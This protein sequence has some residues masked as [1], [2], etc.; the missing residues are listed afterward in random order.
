[1]SNARRPSG[2]RAAAKAEK[3]G[4]KRLTVDFRGHEYVMDGEQVGTVE[5]FE[6][7]EDENYIRALRGMLGREQWTVY[8]ARHP[9]LADID[10]FMNTV[11]EALGQGNSS[12]S[13][14]SPESTARPSKQTSS[15][16][17]DST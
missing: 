16:S 3:D 11:L 8:K 17:T 12:A 7:I 9:Q 1:M 4:P 2:A 6:A 14:T 5:V 13:P 15:G 10:P